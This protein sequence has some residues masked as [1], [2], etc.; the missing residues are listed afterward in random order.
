MK[1]L[2]LPTAIAAI[3]FSDQ[4]QCHGGECKLVGRIPRKVKNDLKVK[5]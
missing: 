2:C 3:I 1:M 4:D 5:C